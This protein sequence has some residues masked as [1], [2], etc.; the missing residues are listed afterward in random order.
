MINYGISLNGL[1]SDELELFVAHWLDVRRKQYVDWDLNPGSGDGGRDVVGFLT[2]AGYEGEWHNYQCKHLSTKLTLPAAI[3]EIAKILMHAAAGDFSL[4]SKYIFVALRGVSR[5]AADEIRHPE[6]FR[7]MIGRDWDALCARRLVKG[8]VILL[9]P[10]ILTALASFNFKGVSIINANKLVL[11]PDIQPVLVRHFGADPGPV[12]PPGACPPVPTLAEAPYLRQLAAAY[13]S[14]AGVVGATAEDLLAHPVW[15]EH[16]RDQRVR[17]FH[18]DRF[19][20]H[21]SERVFEEVLVAFGEEIYHGVVD[22]HRDRSHNDALDQI[23]AVMRA[24]SAVQ[25]TGVLKPHA[26]PQV[27]Q[28]TCHRFANEDRLP[29]G[30]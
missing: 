18:A 23:H 1:Q 15:G 13:G 5:D 11:Q 28:G 8:K 17:Y 10:E 9:S 16:I 25:V 3:L 30:I 24:A 26:N 20:R 19:E 22:T 14:R 27:K 12:P 21:Y 6:R 4:P 2:D 7:R 29:W